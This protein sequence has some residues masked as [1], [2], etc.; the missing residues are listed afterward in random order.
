MSATALITGASNG[1]GLE[2]A[3][4]FASKKNDLVLV[5][6][7]EDKLHALAKELQQLYPIQVHVLVK[8]LS[9]IS[10]AK[11]ID[12]YCTQNNIQVDYLINNAGFGDYGF[13]VDSDWNKQLQMINL[14]ITA[15][16][17]LTRLLLPAMLKRGSGKIMNIASTA[18]FLPGPLMSI[19]YAS[20]AYVLHFSEAISNELEGTGVTVTAFC[21]GATAT[22]FQKVA[23]LEESKMVKGKKMASAEKCAACGYKAM[24]EGKTVAIHGFMNTL[25]IRSI[26]L[27]PRSVV[28]KI[29]RYIQDKRSK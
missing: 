19:Y 20:K 23:A 4:I 25:M 15:L 18:S 29:V 17:Y 13:F 6:R 22:G 10:S 12:D 27:L 11:E 5:A 14:N 24:M 3:K 1:I 21:P 8:D 26:R 2:L 9:V 28:R 16:T 7:S